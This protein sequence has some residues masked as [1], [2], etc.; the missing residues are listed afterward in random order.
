MQWWFFDPVHFT[1]ALG[2]AILQRLYGDEEA[3]Q[4]GTPLSSEM[5]ATHLRQLDQALQGYF[6]D[7]PQDATFVQQIVNQNLPLRKGASHCRQRL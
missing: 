6:R 1:P 5:L 3:L 4:W 2:N 7:H